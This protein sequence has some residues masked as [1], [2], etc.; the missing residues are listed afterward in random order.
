MAISHSGCGMPPRQRPTPSV[1]RWLVGAHAAGDA[2]PAAL[3]SC[4]R[5]DALSTN[6]AAAQ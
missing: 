3:A 2:L 1:C 5:R 6:F 4:D